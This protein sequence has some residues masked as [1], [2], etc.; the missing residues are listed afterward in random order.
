VITAL[1][2]SVV[3]CMEL[4]AVRTHAGAAAID[5]TRE[6][7]ASA[8]A[9]AGANPRAR[10]D[11]N[12]KTGADADVRVARWSSVNVAGLENPKLNSKILDTG[13]MDPLT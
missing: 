10:D 7:R 1:R 9:S 5:A 4:S 13:E 3:A 8:D 6:T 2:G 11:V 12:W